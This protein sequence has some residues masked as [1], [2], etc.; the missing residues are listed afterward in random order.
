MGVSAQLLPYLVDA[1]EEVL[2]G[3]GPMADVTP[4]MRLYLPRVEARLRGITALWF[5]RKNDHLHTIPCNEQ[6]WD[7]E[8]WLTIATSHNT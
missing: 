8:S 6:E 1:L 7:N 3:I 4:T 5:C 2:V